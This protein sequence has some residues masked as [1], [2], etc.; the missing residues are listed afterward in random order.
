MIERELGGD[1][2]VVHAEEEHAAHGEQQRGGERER[3]DPP[4]AGGHRG[5]GLLRRLR[6]VCGA[7]RPQQVG[8]AAA[9][10]VAPR[11]QRVAHGTLPRHAVPARRTALE[12]GLD[13]G[14][15]LG[16]RLAVHVWS[17]RRLQVAAFA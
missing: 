14:A 13:G 4:E 15:L 8:C 10:L 6:G 12:V 7:A 1:G 11:V 3:D 5:S 16:P 9:Q 2:L 17:E